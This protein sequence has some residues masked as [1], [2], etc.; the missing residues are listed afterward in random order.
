MFWNVNVNIMKIKKTPEENYYKKRTEYIRLFIIEDKKINEIS[1]ITGDSKSRARYLIYSKWDLKK[2][3]NPLYLMYKNRR[4]ETD[5]RKIERLLEDGKTR[6][7]IYSKFKEN[8]KTFLSYCKR[9]GV[10]GD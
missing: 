5:K 7:E 9:L 1:E 2:K 8:Y 3:G 6:K 4:E 10:R